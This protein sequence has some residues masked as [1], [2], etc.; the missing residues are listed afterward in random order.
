MIAVSGS[1]DTRRMSHIDVRKILR[2]LT[3]LLLN[4]SPELAQPEST[5]AWRKL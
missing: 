2:R 1:L 4:P 5:P 3:L